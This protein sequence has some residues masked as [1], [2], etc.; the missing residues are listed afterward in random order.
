M[1]GHKGNAN[2]APPIMVKECDKE[3]RP[4]YQTCKAH[5]YLDQPDVLVAK[6]DLLCSLIK[7]SRNMIVYSGAGISTASGIGDYASSMDSISSTKRVLSGFDAQPTTAHFAFTALY[8][9][10]YL[11]CWVQQNHDGLPQKAGFPQDHLNEIH[12]AWYDPSNPVVKMKGE[13]R[14]DLFESLLDWEEKTDLC[15]A[16]GTSL[17]GMNADRVVKTVATKSKKK[18]AFLG[19][20]IINLQQTQLDEI[21][22]LRIFAKINDVM[23]M[24]LQRLELPLPEPVSFLDTTDTFT[25]PYNS[26]GFLD[27]TQSLKMSLKPNSKFTIAHGPNKGC[28]V[29]VDAS[30]NREGHYRLILSQGGS[31]TVLI[32]GKWWLFSAQRGSVDYIPIVPVETP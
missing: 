12:G 15:I 22:S 13:L 17:C 21:S 1:H 14:T 27:S 18:K 11:K 4:G 20:V 32:L 19:A 5:E 23:E 7:R 8:R 29:T 16:V 3:A 25:V 24:V 28:V 30:K 9:A 26:E 31:R 2:W 10:G 6:I